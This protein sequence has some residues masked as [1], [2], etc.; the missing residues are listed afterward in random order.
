MSEAT[1][2][3]GTQL[4]PIDL[5]APFTE[6][7][8]MA[9]DKM[10][11][12]RYAYHKQKLVLILSAMRHYHQE[13]LQ[14]K[15]KVTYHRIDSEDRS[16][17]QDKL[18]KFIDTY[19]ITALHCWE[20]AD[21]SL[22]DLVKKWAQYA[23]VTLVVH[24]SPMFMTSHSQL[25]MYFKEH[26]RP[27]M[28]TFYEMQRNRT[29]ILMDENGKPLGQQYSFDTENRKKLP[30]TQK[31]PQLSPDPHDSITKEVIKIVDSLFSS[32]PGRATDFWLPVTRERALKWLNT[33]ID[34]R[35]MFFGP[36]EDALSQKHDFLFHS[37]LSPL[38][39]TGL[40]TPAETIDVAIMAYAER[41]DIGFG[42]IEG[43]V[44]Q[45][46]GWREFMRAVHYR[47]GGREWHKNYFD[48]TGRLTPK[49]YSA[50]TGIVPLDLL[51]D[52]VKRVGW[53]H[54]IE[55]LMVA[56]NCMLLCGVHPDEV[57]RWFMELFVD[58]SEWVMEPNVYGMSQFSAGG[59]FVTKPYIC[60]SS[61]LLRMSDY[62]KGPWCDIMDSLYWRFVYKN[63]SLFAKNRRTSMA[64]QTVLKMDRL[65]RASM[66]RA[67]E[68]F[69][70]TVVD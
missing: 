34:E 25:D 64:A 41:T 31:V 30:S 56:G 6:S 55:R 54:H 69:I 49:W 11:C 24:E 9:E 47:Q 10:L 57:Y 65:K 19:Q 2:I 48:H 51:I 68:M 43:F 40:L 8:F 22:A 15:I 46:M 21:A 33:F 45:I 16:S 26:S 20:I 7:V 67:A 28:R 35:L 53:A 3:V 61:Y 50:Q 59:L 37:L 62:S 13:L 70:A 23:G 60:A 42:S 58:A 17:Y 66:I 18:K 29:G 44:R 1:L 5:Y 39:N 36:Y 52:K 14:K 32:N 12:T 4:F 63:K 27:L 38:L